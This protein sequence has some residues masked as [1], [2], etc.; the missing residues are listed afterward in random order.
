M[1]VKT[2]PGSSQDPKRVWG[3]RDGCCLAAERHRSSSLHLCATQHCSTRTM[4]SPARRSPRDSH[5]LS[6]PV[7][8]HHVTSQLQ[9]PPTPA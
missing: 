8:S 1:G 2:A 5:V 6:C 4:P 9:P 7:L 3:T